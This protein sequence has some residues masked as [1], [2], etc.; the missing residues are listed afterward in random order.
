MMKTLN[1]V[2]PRLYPIKKKRVMKGLAN[3][4]R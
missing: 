2:I 1:N 3:F 4:L